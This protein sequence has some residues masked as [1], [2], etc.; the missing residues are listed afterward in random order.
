MERNDQPVG[1]YDHVG[2]ARFAIARARESEESDQS[3]LWLRQAQ[4]EATLAV[5]AALES[6]AE[7]VVEHGNER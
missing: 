2:Q 4:V 1:P 6:L 7:A 5:A 3:V